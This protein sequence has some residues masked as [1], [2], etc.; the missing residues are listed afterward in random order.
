MSPHQKPYV[1][2]QKTLCLY[3]KDLTSLPQR[4]HLFTSKTS[5]LYLKDLT[6][7]KQCA[8]MKAASSLSAVANLRKTRQIS[9]KRNRP[10]KRF[11]GFDTPSKCVSPNA[12][13]GFVK[14]AAQKM[15]KVQIFSRPSAHPLNTRQTT[16]FQATNMIP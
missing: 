1:S 4:P 11:S 16:H 6:T 2:T 9:S 12:F 13:R 3:L 5:P 10:K 8:V 15:G 14:S 7:L